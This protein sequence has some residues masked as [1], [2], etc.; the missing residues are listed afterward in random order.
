MAVAV[1]Q[2]RNQI[3]QQSIFR[4]LLPCSELMTFY[5]VIVSRESEDNEVKWH[6][7]LFPESSLGTTVETRIQATLFLS[8]HGVDYDGDGMIFV[9]NQGNELKVGEALKIKSGDLLLWRQ[10]NRHCVGSVVPVTG[11]VGFVRIVYPMLKVKTVGP[12]AV[13]PATAPSQAVEITV[14]PTIRQRLGRVARRVGIYD[15]LKKIGF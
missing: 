1:T 5:K 4:A 13:R 11:G 6:R 8:E 10:Y 9:D 3:E 15:S 14:A 12:S 2:L 7:D